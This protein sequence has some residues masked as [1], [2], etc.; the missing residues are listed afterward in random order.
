V[1]KN[2]GIVF[3]DVISSEQGL[4]AR[5]RGADGLVA[6]G[7]GAGSHCGNI[8]TFILVPYLRYRTSLPVLAAGGISTGAQMAAALA[9]GACGVVV[10]TR[11]IATAES[12]APAAY[13]QAVIDTA[14]EEIVTS[15]EITGN[16]ATWLPDSIREYREHPE[17]DWQGWQDLWSAG[18]SVAQ[19]DAVK[20]V[21]AV[22]REIVEEYVRVCGDLRQSVVA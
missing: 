11:L 18:Q 7:A 19:V 16:P 8:P 17:R 3:A 13:K 21:A 9:V 4:K 15:S 5:D 6:V 1:H 14:P 22:V 10:G 12:G 20:P 2:G